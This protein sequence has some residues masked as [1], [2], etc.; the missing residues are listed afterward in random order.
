MTDTEQTMTETAV[1]PAEPDTAENDS[2]P[3]QADD[4]AKESA[5]KDEK[6]EDD[7][8][9]EKKSPG[10]KSPRRRVSISLRSLAAGALIATLVGTIGALAWLYLGAQ[11]KFDAQARQSANNARAEKIAL[12][13]AVNAAA[14]NAQ[15]INAWK[16]KLVA[17]TTPE[18]KEKLTK[19]AGSMEQI[20]VPLQWSSSASPLV[21]KVRSN[22]GAAYVVDAFVSVQTKT[23]QAPEPLQSTA[24]YSI[25][26]DSNKDWQ[27]S[28][29]GGIGAMVEG[30]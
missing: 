4:A 7:E 28:D 26:I 11:H 3:P 20:L 18:L 23:M 14:M 6:P 10:N 29:V 12:D 13:Y 27:I 9:K 30:K 22:S 15:D 24:A 5:A 17:G 2:V 25:T 1:E 19:A 8:V 16:T 21:A